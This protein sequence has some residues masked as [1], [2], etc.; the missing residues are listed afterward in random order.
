MLRYLNAAGTCTKEAMT[1]AT[2]PRV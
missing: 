2:S 1:S